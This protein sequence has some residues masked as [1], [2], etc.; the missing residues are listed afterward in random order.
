MINDI[1]R[2]LDLLLK[3]YLSDKRGLSSKD[4][5]NE[6]K[7]ILEIKKEVLK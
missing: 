7:L 1:E 4:I 2:K 6:D 5:L 3:C